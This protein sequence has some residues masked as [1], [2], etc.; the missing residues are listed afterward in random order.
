MPLRLMQVALPADADGTADRLL[1]N[2]DI[3]GTWQDPS[4]QT[5]RVI[6]VLV[7]ADA[8][9]PIMDKLEQRYS[10]RKGFR[11]LLMSVEAS[12][13]RM[14]A[15]DNGAPHA[16]KAAADKVEKISKAGR[17]SREELYRDISESLGVNRVFLAMA[18]LSSIVA[19]IGLLRDDVAVIIGAMVIAPLLGPNVAMALATTLGDWK[20]LRQSLWTNAV[21]VA[22]GLGIAV[23]VGLVFEIDLTIPAI[24]SRTQVGPGDLILALAAGAA[25]AFAFTRGLSGAMIGV[26]VAVA[27]MPPL[28]TFGMLLGSGDFTHAA[29]AL[30]L[31]AINV[32]CV[33]LAGVATFV[34]QGVWPRTWWEGERAKRA[35]RRAIVTWLVVLVILIALLWITRVHRGVKTSLLDQH[36]NPAKLR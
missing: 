35:T 11:V 9:E 3:V 14:E 24:A 28:V 25:G 5:Q 6:Q 13:P 4:E 32:V 2:Y 29:G 26:M 34:A 12:L 33:N 31:V 19:A 18:G 23:V 20:L 1:E 22:C 21:G 17:V 8:A 16:K 27:L 30:L 15:D 36:G 10:G 7:P